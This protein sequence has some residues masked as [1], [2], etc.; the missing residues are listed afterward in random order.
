M[1]LKVTFKKRPRQTGLARVAEPYSSTDIKVKGVEIGYIAPPHR[2]DPAYLWT[3]RF[4]VH[5][6][7][8]ENCKWRWATMKARHA[9]EPDAR[10]W[11]LANI[12]VVQSHLS[13]VLEPT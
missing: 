5:D 2:T 9:T 6:P 12:G 10:E 3:V 13:L 7:E 8:G 11:V 1:P 4:K